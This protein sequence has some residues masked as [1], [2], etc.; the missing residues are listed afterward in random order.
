MGGQEASHCR[1]GAAKAKAIAQF[2]SD[3]GAVQ[4]S[5]IGQ[6][7]VQ[8]IEDFGGPRIAMIAAGRLRDKGLALVAPLLAELVEPR[9]ADAEALLRSA[10]VDLAIVESSQDGADDFGGNSM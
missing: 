9:A 5:T 8:K 4:R 3:E 7:G 1:A 2:V 10:R 6:E